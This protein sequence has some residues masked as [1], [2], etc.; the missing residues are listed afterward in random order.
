M[1]YK[2][3]KGFKMQ[4]QSFVPWGS[5]QPVSG[6]AGRL[7]SS[8][9]LGSSAFCP[10]EVGDDLEERAALR[11]RSMVLR[12]SDHFTA[13]AGTHPELAP[14]LMESLGNALEQLLLFGRPRDLDLLEEW[15]DEENL[16]V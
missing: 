10:T 3:I 15:L 2:T 9:E 6:R 4:Y 13:A 8:E 7:G 12:L 14:I 11:W 5:L 16:N 1:V